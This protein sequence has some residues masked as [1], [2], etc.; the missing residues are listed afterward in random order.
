MRPDAAAARLRH[1]VRDGEI[2]ERARELRA[3]GETKAAA[4]RAT[5]RGA[6]AD[7]VV[8]GHLNG[9]VDVLTE[10]YLSVYLPSDRW[11][12]RARLPISV[13]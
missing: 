3:L 12:G 4:H 6:M 2:R 11:D 8:S 9:K 1:H 7:G 5:R 13:D 10:D